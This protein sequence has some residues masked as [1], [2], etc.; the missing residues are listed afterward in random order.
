MASADAAT[1]IETRLNTYWAGLEP[2]ISWYL[3]EKTDPSV[4]S[5]I[6][7]MFMLL[8]FPGGLSQQASIG[9]PG[10][11][12]WKEIGTFILHIY[13]PAGD[14]AAAARAA[15]KNA[16]T[17]YRGVSE[18]GIIYRAPFPP[19]PGREGSLS[20]NWMSLSMSVPYEY[21]IRA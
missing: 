20:G 21:R 12:W 9:A 18:N 11:N 6:T 14:T 19:Q 4:G 1:E 2:D 8:E 10:D 15:L 5:D 13:Y 17:I 16:A 3:W 7:N